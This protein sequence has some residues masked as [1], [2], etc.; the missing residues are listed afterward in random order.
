[1]TTKTRQLAGAINQSPIITAIKANP[2][3]YTIESVA[4]VSAGFEKSYRYA[5]DLEVNTGTLKLFLHKNCTLTELDLFVDTAPV[6]SAVTIDL[7]KNGAS[8]ATPSIA[9]GLT[10]NVGVTVDV[11]FAAGDYLT[12]DIT[13]VGSTTPGSNLYAVLSFI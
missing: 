2:T 3:T 10:S 13:Q 11:S 9:D 12:V 4:A 6:G 7:K 8:I 5:G 1:M